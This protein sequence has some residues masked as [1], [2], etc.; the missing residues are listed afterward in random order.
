MISCEVRPE[1]RA[2]AVGFELLKVLPV[3]FYLIKLSTEVH[4]GK[5]V[6]VSG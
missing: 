3:S 6:R 1:V 5:S 4:D 2:S